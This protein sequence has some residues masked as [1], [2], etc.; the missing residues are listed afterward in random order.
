MAQKSTPSPST[1]SRSRKAPPPANTN[2]NSLAKRDKEP[3]PEIDED[4]AERLVELLAAITETTKPAT[5]KARLLAFIIE[6]DRLKQLFP[7]HQRVADHIGCS[8]DNI[9]TALNDS[10]KR[11][12]VTQEL[13]FVPGNIARRESTTRRHRYAPTRRLAPVTSLL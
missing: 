9:R 1:R 5:K 6:M 7:T 4:L 13:V 3:L 10:I 8:V 11:K 12:L 2:Y